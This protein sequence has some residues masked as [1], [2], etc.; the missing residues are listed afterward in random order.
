MQGVNKSMTTDEI[1][2]YLLTLTDREREEFLDA[3][4]AEFCRYCGSDAPKCYCMCDD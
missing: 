1:I 4:V 3:F 2:A